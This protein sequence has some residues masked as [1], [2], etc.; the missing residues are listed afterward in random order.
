[1]FKMNMADPWSEE[2][3]RLK[4]RGADFPGGMGEW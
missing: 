4:R 3:P 2:M 1:M